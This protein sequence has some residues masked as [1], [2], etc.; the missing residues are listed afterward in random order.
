MYGEKFEIS[1]KDFLIALGLA[2]PTLGLLSYEAIRE[3]RE[4]EVDEIAENEFIYMVYS[5]LK[6]SSYK[7]YDT[8]YEN[9]MQSKRWSNIVK[10][11]DR[12]DFERVY[13]TT[14][15]LLAWEKNKTRS[16]LIVKRARKIDDYVQIVG[17]YTMQY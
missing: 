5:F 1:R 6:N 12:N 2:I 9:L 15:R 14:N 10:K 17:K 4:S 8:A 11:F 13:H 7:D 3:I 16:E